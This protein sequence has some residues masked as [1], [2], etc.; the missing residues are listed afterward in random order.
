V[1]ITGFY[2]MQSENEALSVAIFKSSLP[3]PVSGSLR[4][5]AS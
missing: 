4:E 2:F 5:K 1:D 3:H